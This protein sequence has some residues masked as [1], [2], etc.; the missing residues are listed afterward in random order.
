MEGINFVFFVVI[1]IISL[2]SAFITCRIRKIHVFVKP[3]PLFSLSLL[4][5]VNILIFKNLS[6]FNFCI[7]GGLILGMAGDTFLLFMDK[8]FLHG[9]LA[10]L[11]GHIC[12]I[13]AFL[14]KTPFAY[15]STTIFIFIIVIILIAGTYVFILF[16]KITGE[17][18]KYMIP[19][20]FYVIVIS[21][22]VICGIR[23]ELFLG[24][25]LPVFIIG[26]LLF[27]L[28]DAV[29]AWVTFVHA[30]S[31][32]DPIVLSTY[33]FAQIAITYQAL[34]LMA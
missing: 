4:F 30:Y 23:I 6:F 1:S 7:L 33:Y 14:T 21:S 16:K 3:I 10:F 13:V 25:L 24:S 20:F 29:L 18:K 2:V 34:F 26:S 32:G 12:Y 11:F 22:M 19:I 5:L 9:L 8:Y 15:M 28:S 31:W 17:N 27:F